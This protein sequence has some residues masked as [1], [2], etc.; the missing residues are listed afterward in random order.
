MQLQ[1]YIE[2]LKS[3]GYIGKFYIFYNKLEKKFY[4]YSKY[5][6]DQ[7]E[8]LFENVDLEFVKIIEILGGNN[9]A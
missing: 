5:I 1:N 8:Q 3:K 6:V 4:S 9:N 7:N 2:S